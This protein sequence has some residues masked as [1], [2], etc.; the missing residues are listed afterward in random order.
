MS[1]SAAGFG[2]R[3]NWED[4]EVPSGHGL[5]FKRSIEIVSTGL[6]IRLLCP[7]RIFEWAPIGKIREVRD[8]FAEFRVCLQRI[9]PHTDAPG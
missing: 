5:S 8:G 6:F 2:R 4:D 9:L 3:I 1:I 7:E